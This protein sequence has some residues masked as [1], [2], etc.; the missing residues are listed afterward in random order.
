MVCDGEAIIP[1]DGDVCG[2]PIGEG[3]GGGG[4]GDGCG[5][6]L[7]MVS[8]AQP[9]CFWL[10]CKMKFKL[11]KQSV[12]K[13]RPDILMGNKGHWLSSKIGQDCVSDS[14]IYL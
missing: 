7:A 12:K 11:F 3:A 6:G 13:F 4:I 1:G 10:L 5:E 14:K 2:G 8:T 9:Q